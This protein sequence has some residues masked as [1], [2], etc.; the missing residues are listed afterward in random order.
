MNPALPKE[1]LVKRRKGWV[2]ALILA[3]GYAIRLQPLTVNTPK[4]LLD[5][6]GRTI[7]DRI[8]AKVFALKETD[9]V[10]VITNDKFFEKFENWRKGSK[11]NARISLTNDGTSSNETRLGAIKDL[12]I[13][14]RENRIEDDLLVV[15]GDNIFEFGLRRLVKFAKKNRDGVT[16]ALHDVK[17][18]EAAKR[19]GVVELGAGGKVT[20]FEE[21]PAHPKSTLIST[22]V[23]YFPKEDLSSIDE[24]ILNES[25]KS[26]APG[27]YM[28]W[29]ARRGKAYGYAFNEAWYDIGDIESYKKADK[30]Y[31]EKGKGDEDGQR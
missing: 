14:I 25:V 6:G 21:K 3:A 28:S 31:S 15:A 27:Y 8:I 19:F 23:Y 16:I 22:G 5:I 18:V 17:D 29:L 12:Q 11:Y 20:G 10:Y 13:A 1:V 2:K 4:P 30:E 26:D 7:I 24:Y 9:S